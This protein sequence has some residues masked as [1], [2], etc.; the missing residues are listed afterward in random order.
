MHACH[1]PGK[2]RK[3]RGTRFNL[4]P[5]PGHWGFCVS[6]HCKVDHKDSACRSYR[7]VRHFTKTRPVGP[8]GRYATSQRHGL[9]VLQA[10]TP[11]HKTHKS[12][13]PSSLRSLSNSTCRRKRNVPLLRNVAR[14]RGADKSLARTRKDTSLEAC[15]GR[16]RLQRHRDASC[17]QVPPPTPCKAPKE[18]HAILTETL[19]CLL[20]GRAKAL[21]APVYSLPVTSACNLLNLTY[22]LPAN[23]KFPPG[24][25]TK[26][27]LHK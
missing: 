22:I 11:I 16:A 5:C 14:Y 18:I 23:L 2:N 10:G 1:S 27:M 7:P 21:P 15:Q 4:R 6:S 24:R 12:E 20:P 9:S 17:H 26:H 19:A 8:T 25:H 3:I 13:L